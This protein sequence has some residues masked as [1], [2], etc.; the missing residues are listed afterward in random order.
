VV[1]ASKLYELEG[2]PREAARL[3]RRA[4]QVDPKNLP[5]RL[6]LISLYEQMR[7]L[8]EALEVCQDTLA[9]DPENPDL[10]WR[11]GV[12]HAQTGEFGEAEAALQKVI[13]LAPKNAQGYAGLAEVYL[14]AKRQPDE[15][16]RLAREAVRLAP[17]ALHYALL[18]RV[19]VQA[20][21]WSGA[22]ASLGEA[23]KREPNNQ[24]YRQLHQ[25]LGA[26]QPRS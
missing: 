8:P 20:G 7:R 12:L 1:Y 17:T 15:A 18:G 4:T 23:V 5:A 6:T 13:Q 22:Q 9:V 26:M 2:D 3:C 10:L 19:Q 11:L 21:D 14:N 24:L 16:L 25:Q